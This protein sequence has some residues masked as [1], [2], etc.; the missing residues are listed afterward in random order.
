MSRRGAKNKKD[1]K[2]APEEVSEGNPKLALTL[3]K[4][5]KTHQKLIKQSKTFYTQALVTLF[6]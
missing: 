3:K 2:K 5:K 4:L 6:S 1:L